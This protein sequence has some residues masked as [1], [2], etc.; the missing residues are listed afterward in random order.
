M[1]KFREPYDVK[2]SIFTRDKIMK[3]IKI[4]C[5]NNI[6][7]KPRIEVLEKLIYRNKD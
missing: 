6:T 7:R 1:K 4:R 5:K 2:I 3:R